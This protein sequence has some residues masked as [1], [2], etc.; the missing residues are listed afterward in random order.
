MKMFEYSVTYHYEDFGTIE[1]ESYEDAIAQIESGDVSYPVT[2]AGFAD[3]WS[4]V[5]IDECYEIAD[6]E[7]DE[8]DD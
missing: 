7:E 1:A 3:S 8:D 5:K 4:Y 6:D 2:A